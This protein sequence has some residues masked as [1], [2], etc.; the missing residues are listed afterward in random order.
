MSDLPLGFD[1]WQIIVIGLVLF[2]WW[3]YNRLEKHMKETRIDTWAKK[4]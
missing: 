4:E 3:G 2:M 1:Y